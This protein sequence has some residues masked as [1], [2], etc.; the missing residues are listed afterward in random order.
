[1]ERQPAFGNLMLLADP[2]HSF[3]GPRPTIFPGIPGPDYLTRN[4]DGS[5]FSISNLKTLTL[6]NQKT[7][8]VASLAT[9][10]TGT[11]ASPWTGWD[12]A[13]V[14]A[15]NTLY[16]CRA[17]YY[18]ASALIFES[19]PAA[20][21]TNITIEGEA[22]TVL[23]FTGSLTTS[24][25]G[26]YIEAGVGLVFASDSADNAV[27]PRNCEVRHVTIDGMGTAKIGLL[28]Q[29][30]HAV[31]TDCVRIHDV[32]DVA[33]KMAWCVLGTHNKFTTSIFGREHGVLPERGVLITHNDYD[34]STAQLFFC[35]IIEGTSV[36][37]FDLDKAGFCQIYGGTCEVGTGNAF[38]ISA[39]SF[40]NH[41]MDLDCE[42]NTGL[43]GSVID[44]FANVL[45]NVQ[46]VNETLTVNGND[47]T[48]RDGYVTSLVI[49]AGANDTRLR[50][51]NGPGGI[52]VAYTDNGTRTV[53]PEAPFK[54]YTPTVTSLGGAF[55]AYTATGS[56]KQIGKL[57]SVK[58]RLVLTTVGAASGHV[59]A[60]LPTNSTGDWMLTGREDVLTGFGVSGHIEASDPTKVYIT[61]A[62]DNSFPGASGSRI[63]L[64]GVYEI[65]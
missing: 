61:F 39:L 21:L 36:W 42:A 2:Q 25:A 6:V 40:R 50:A 10:G 46:L 41:I 9:G 26:G 49:G 7:V 43:A 19:T 14:K 37:G 28:F 29:A 65:P 52:A 58:M 60:S 15:S 22:G 4:L 11:S 1:L 38:R 8:D 33:M 35:P 48:L 44:G 56:Y 30:A 12:T 63:V 17:G 3:G 54:T 23:Q 16:K 47:N 64:S 13:L 32:T 27:M 18:R 55:G 24:G 59:I 34:F 31:A 62:S 53:F 5:G 20:V 57:M 51:V 45:D